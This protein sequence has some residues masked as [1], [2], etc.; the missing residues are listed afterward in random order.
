MREL[1]APLWQ[2]VSPQ[3]FL[4][5]TPVLVEAASEADDGWQLLVLTP[6]NKPCACAGTPQGAEHRR[7]VIMATS[8]RAG[9]GS[10]AVP[11]QATHL[12]SPHPLAVPPAVH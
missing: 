5:R 4:A 7:R 6:I 3:Q 11:S 8:P 2:G 10:M 12:R 9:D 1:A